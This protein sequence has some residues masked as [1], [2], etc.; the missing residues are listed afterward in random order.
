MA[1]R[2][3]RYWRS[4]ICTSPATGLRPHDAYGA[5]RPHVRPSRRPTSLRKAPFDAP[6]DRKI[7]LLRGSLGTVITGTTPPTKDSTNY[8]GGKV[9]FMAPVD[10]RHGTWIQK[11]DKHVT[12]SALQKLRPIHPGAS[13][14]VCIGS[15][16][17]KVGY[18]NN[19]ICATN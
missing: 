15:S 1:H 10:I 8:V 9:P 7:A 14:F 19:R 4:P 2:C 3:F 18:V 16:I 5:K 13:C 17:G 6:V 11:T 12:E